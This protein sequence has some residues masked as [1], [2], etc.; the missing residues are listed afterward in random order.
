MV[1]QYRFGMCL[2]C[3]THYSVRGAHVNTNFRLAAEVVN[4]V[5]H[6]HAAKF[7]G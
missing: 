2:A 7:R 4:L 6:L 5:R 1:V 3:G